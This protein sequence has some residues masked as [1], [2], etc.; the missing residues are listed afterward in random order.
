MAAHRKHPPKD[1]AE[2]IRNLAA[3]GFSMVGIAMHFKVSSPTVKRWL[4]EDEVLQEAFEMGRETERQY[5]HS[6]VVQS[7]AAGRAANVNAFFLLK[8]RHGYRETD[9]PNSSVNVGVQVAPVM[10][11]KDHGTD[12]EWERKTAEHQRRL[13]Q[14]GLSG[15]TVHKLEAS[16]GVAQ[17]LPIPEPQAIPAK[18]PD[19]AWMPPSIAWK[20][21][22]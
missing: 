20:G 10:V 17:P 22:P 1:A 19:A 18:A 5:L 11:V 4:E 2:T 6:L 3:Q 13:T 12:E 14:S 7:A 8:A 9:P 16:Q 15:A 21:N